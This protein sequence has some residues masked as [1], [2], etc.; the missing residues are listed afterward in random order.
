M[1]M[2]AGEWRATRATARTTAHAAAHVRAPARARPAAGG[3][4]GFTVLVLAGLGLAVL[5]LVV[6]ALWPRWPDAPAADAPALPITI[7]DVLFSV[8]PLAIRAAI[9]RRAGAQERIDLVY[10][11]PSLAPPEPETPDVRRAQ[12]IAGADR[13]FVTI[14]VAE[15]LPPLERLKTIYPRYAATAPSAGP[16]GL[17]LVAFRDGT[18]YQGEDLAFDPETPERFLARCSRSINPLTPGTCLHARRIGEADLTVRFPRDW[19]EKWRDVES[20]LDRLIAQ[21]KPAGGS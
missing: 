2:L 9:Q 17:A 1:A 4:L 5:L 8:P 20:G 16:Q 11:W 6:Y 13:V 21:L 10:L 14:A 3:M 19:L 18:P 15:S 7:A 12:D